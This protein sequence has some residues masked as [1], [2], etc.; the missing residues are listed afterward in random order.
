MY[1]LNGIIRSVVLISPVG[2]ES[3]RTKTRAIISTEPDCS[4]RGMNVVLC[5][6]SWQMGQY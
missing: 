4:D 1:V 5:K 3:W 6:E 2:L